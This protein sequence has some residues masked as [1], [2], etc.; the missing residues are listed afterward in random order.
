MKTREESPLPLCPVGHRKMVR[1]KLKSPGFGNYGFIR[2]FG[3]SLPGKAEDLCMDAW[4]CTACGQVELHAC[5][6]ESSLLDET[7]Y[8]GDE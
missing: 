4:V 1:A 8:G 7:Q 5:V 6:G 3:E 2:P